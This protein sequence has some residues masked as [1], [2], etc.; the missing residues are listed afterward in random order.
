[1]SVDGYS[2]VDNFIEDNLEGYDSEDV[3][4]EYADIYSDDEEFEE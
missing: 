1:M 4:D 2:S 3:F